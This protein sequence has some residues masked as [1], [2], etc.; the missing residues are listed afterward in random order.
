LRT[1]TAQIRLSAVLILSIGL[2][3]L[4]AIAVVFFRIV[5]EV[6][7]ALTSQSR[8]AYSRVPDLFTQH[9]P[10]AIQLGLG[11]PILWYIMKNF[12]FNAVVL[13]VVSSTRVG[14]T[15][16][17]VIRLLAAL[18]TVLLGSVIVE[19]L[20]KFNGM[21]TSAT[22]SVVVAIAIIVSAL[23]TCIQ[24]LYP[25]V[26]QYPRP[27][28]LA[29]RALGM[30]KV[31]VLHDVLYDH[32]VKSLRVGASI[33]LSRVLVEMLI[34]LGGF[35]LSGK[36][37]ATLS[38]KIDAPQFFMSAYASITV[39]T[40]VYVILLL[41]LIALFGRVWTPSLSVFGRSLKG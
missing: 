30:D 9:L 28:F 2:I 38:D 21:E 5:Y 23:P 24:I 20:S 40:N 26:Y 27:E 1:L 6:L 7:P 37:S 32:F 31:F 8:D 13:L 25:V 39:R 29:A 33:S 17:L 34:I 12:T 10:L 41:V 4:V 19:G 14:N 16:E 18:P 36:L 3:S 11:L 35:E 15:V 22:R